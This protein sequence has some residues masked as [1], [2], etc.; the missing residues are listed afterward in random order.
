M[1]SEESESVTRNLSYLRALGS[2]SPIINRIVNLLP[3]C[4]ELSCLLLKRHY[5]RL[6]VK[7]KE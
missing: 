7:I 3:I 5:K 6:F 1:V 4:R 2:P